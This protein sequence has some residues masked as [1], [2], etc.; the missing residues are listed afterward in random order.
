[1]SDPKPLLPLTA[2][3]YHILLALADDD[4]HGYGIIKDVEERTGEAAQIETGAVYHAIRRMRSDGLIEP[5]PAAE[6][7]PS[8][9]SRRRTYRIT[10]WG[11]EVLVAETERLRRLVEIADAK[12]VLPVRVT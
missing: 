3:T 11:R 12:Q 4:R 10:A 5:V 9:D 8:E 6:R 1:M 7:P 2:L